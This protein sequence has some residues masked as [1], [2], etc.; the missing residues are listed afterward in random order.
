LSIDEHIQA[1]ELELLTSATRKNAERVSALLAEDFRE[2][3]SSG[4]VYSKKDII[5]TLQLETPFIISA[6]DVEI[7][8]LAEHVALVTYKSMKNAQAA[9]SDSALRSSIWVKNGEQWN[10]VFHQGT[11]LP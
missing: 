9:Q 5:S 4:R 8:W 7:S 2:F 3:G 10:M 1:L 6:V 11:K